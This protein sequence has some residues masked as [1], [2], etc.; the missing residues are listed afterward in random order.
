ME[1][2]DLVRRRRM[3]RTFEQKPIPDD[4]LTRVLEV[5]RH[6]PSGGLSQLGVMALGV[7]V[8]G[9]PAERIRLTRRRRPFEEMFHF[10]RR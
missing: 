4:V 10:G 1:F 5:A 9:W 7:S 6:G 2:L 8:C 3:V